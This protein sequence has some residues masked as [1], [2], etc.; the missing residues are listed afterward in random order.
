MLPWH[1]AVCATAQIVCQMAIIYLYERSAYYTVNTQRQK[2]LIAVNPILH[3]LK[4]HSKNK[5]VLL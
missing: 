1:P 5:A 3:S 4:S 2:K